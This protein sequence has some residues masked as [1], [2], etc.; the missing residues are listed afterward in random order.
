MSSSKAKVLTFYGIAWLMVLVI[1]A[2]GLMFLR[3]WGWSRIEQE[4]A[5]TL[6]AQT[7]DT[8]DR[9]DVIQA[10]KTVV[11]LLKARPDRL[12]DALAVFDTDTLGMPAVIDVVRASPEFRE[13][14]Q[15]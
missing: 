5:Q 14:P 3:Q 13:L 6:F 9:G 4:H 15:M 8:F 7:R 1:G 11:Q 12:P 2:T 10:Q